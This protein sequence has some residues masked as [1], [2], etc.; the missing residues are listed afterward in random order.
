MPRKKGV[1]DQTK[2]VSR[3]VRLS[4]KMDYCLELLARKQHRSISSLLEWLI[5]RAIQD[6][7]E[8]LWRLVKPNEDPLPLYE[9][10]WDANPVIRIFNLM[11]FWPELLTFE[12]ELALEVLKNEDC[13]FEKKVSS[14]DTIPGPIGVINRLTDRK[15]N[16]PLIRKNW[17]VIVAKANGDH[18]VKFVGLDG[19]ELKPTRGGKHGS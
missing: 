10:V 13:F 1:F 11:V 2:G 18:T 16:Y 7:H 12:E 9:S 19:K 15:P 14:P 3:T 6:K 4:P 5:D 17:E 8:G